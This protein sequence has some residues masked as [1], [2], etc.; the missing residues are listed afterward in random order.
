LIATRNAE[1]EALAQILLTRL[2][3]IRLLTQNADVHPARQVEALRARLIQNL[4]KLVENI[5]GLDQARLHQEAVLLAVKSDIREEL[6]RLKAH[7]DSVSELLAKGGPIGRRLDF[8]AQELGRESNTLCAKSNDPALT[9]IGLDLENKFKTSNNP[10]IAL[11]HLEKMRISP[12]N[13]R[14]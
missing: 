11:L 13:S 3:H 2:T 4:V 9:A 6:D 12:I 1:G 14:K 10:F 5:E 8:L 7:A